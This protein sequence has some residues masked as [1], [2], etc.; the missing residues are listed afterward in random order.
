MSTQ[1]TSIFDVIVIGGG[2][3]GLT[4][5]AYRAKSGLKVAVIERNDKSP[6]PN[7]TYLL[8]LHEAHWTSPFGNRVPSL[9]NGGL[10]HR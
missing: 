10:W 2:A 8:D 4:T 1:A 9:S 3:N 6:Y 7:L 5:A